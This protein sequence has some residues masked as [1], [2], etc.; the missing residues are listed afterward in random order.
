MGGKAV[1]ERVNPFALVDLRFEFGE[2]V[3]PLGVVDRY[4]TALSVGEQVNRRTM[5]FPIRAQLGQKPGRQD[6]VAVFS[7]P[8]PCST[9]TIIRSLSMALTLSRTNS[10]TRNPVA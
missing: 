2:I 5:L 1:P 4:R 8:L 6:R 7:T 10:L 3:N 9:R